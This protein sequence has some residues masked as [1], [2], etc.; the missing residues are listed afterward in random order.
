[1]RNSNTKLYKFL[2]IILLFVYLKYHYFVQRLNLSAVTKP[3]F[4]RVL[5]D[6]YF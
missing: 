1:M 5:R 6:T 3:S 2:L 4:A